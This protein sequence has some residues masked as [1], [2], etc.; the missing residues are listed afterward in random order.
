MSAP[1][2]DIRVLSRSEL[3]RVG[4]IDRSER[5]EVLYDQHGATLIARRGEWAAPA[6]DPN[7][8]GP[9]SVAAQLHALERDLD[10]GGIALGAFA[11]ERLVG[12]GV[13]IPHLRPSIAQLAFLHVDAAWRAMGVG[14]RLAE[15]L[16][17]IA[18][19]A[20]DV[21]MVVSATPTGNTVRFYLGL[22]FQPMAEP[23]PELFELEPDDVHLR[24]AL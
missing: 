8:D 17:Q 13:V 15:E 19:T 21:D 11:A 7:G 18:R 4:E 10:L 12:I 2:A 9:H 23:L 1:T 24:K 14:T 5:I 20:G 16:Q 3:R 6:W 22:G